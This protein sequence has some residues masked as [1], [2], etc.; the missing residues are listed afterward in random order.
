[1]LYATNKQVVTKVEGMDGMN[2]WNNSNREDKTA[3]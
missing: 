3:V 2:E 1:M